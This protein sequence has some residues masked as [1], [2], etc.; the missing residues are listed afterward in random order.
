[1]ERKPRPAGCRAARP[2]R[3]HEKSPLTQKSCIRNEGKLLLLQKLLDASLL[4]GLKSDPN[5][6]FLCI[7]FGKACEG[8]G[9]N[10]TY[11]RVL[12]VC[13]HPCL[14]VYDQP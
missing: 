9:C 10:L 2:H 11:R 4:P 5:F 6:F 7:S 12:C 14:F 3:R 8:K 13:A 1:M